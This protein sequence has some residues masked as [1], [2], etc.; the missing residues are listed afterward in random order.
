MYI[1]F[2][3][4]NYEKKKLYT[5]NI[6]GVN[7]HLDSRF[8]HLGPFKDTTMLKVIVGDVDED[9]LFTKPFYEMDV[10]ENSDIGTIVGMVTAYDPD[11]RSSSVR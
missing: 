10:Y 5:L 3:P 9:P 7:T 8:S 6:E 2:Q 1:F 11:S 4:L